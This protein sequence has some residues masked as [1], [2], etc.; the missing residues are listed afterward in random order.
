MKIRKKGL[1]HKTSEFLVLW[2]YDSHPKWCHP[3]MVSSGAGRPP[4]PPA[5]PL[6]CRFLALDGKTQRDHF[7]VLRKSGFCFP[8]C[9]KS[10][11]II[12]V[13][14]NYLAMYSWATLRS[15][16][17]VR[18]TGNFLMHF[19]LLL[20]EFR[21]HSRI[22]SLSEYKGKTRYIRMQE[23]RSL[24]ICVRLKW[25]RLTRVYCTLA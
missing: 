4:P 3:N 21:C 19:A 25:V 24:T 16:C 6:Y 7:A 5:T 10:Y 23:F 9:N 8:L 22:A 14:S 1:R 13:I 20:L 2:S 11:A 15:N 12:V 17:Y 18:L